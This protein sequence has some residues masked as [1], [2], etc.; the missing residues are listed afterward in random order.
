MSTNRVDKPKHMTYWLARAAREL[1]ESSGGNITQI[2]ADHG[3]RE[4]SVSRFE[5]GL[6]VP[7]YLDAM[8]ETYANET[9]HDPQE[10]WERALQLWDAHE[11]AEERHRPQPRAV[12]AKP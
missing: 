1:R 4:V 12:G 9:G 5:R 10:F 2:A 6:H 11:N 7:K 3:V 8:I